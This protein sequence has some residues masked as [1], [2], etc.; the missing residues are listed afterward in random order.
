[1]NEK[2]KALETQAGAETFYAWG[3][4]EVTTGVSDS[5]AFLIVDE[6][7]GPNANCPQPNGHCTK[8][9]KV[10]LEKFVE[11]IVKECIGIV[12]DTTND[13]EW[14]S[15]NRATANAIKEHFGVKE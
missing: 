4:E 10:D 7:R 14:D 9:H 2:I 13:S 8:L 15:Y 3:S 6:S 12:T 1:M 5:S 11:L